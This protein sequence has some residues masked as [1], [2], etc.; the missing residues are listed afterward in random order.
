MQILERSSYLIY[1]ILIVLAILISIF[2]FYLTLDEIRKNREPEIFAYCINLEDNKKRWEHMIQE[3]K[4]VSF[5]I[6]RIDAVD[7][8]HS[9]WLNYIDMIEDESVQKLKDTIS[10]KIRKSDPD[11]TPGAVG[12]F[13]SHLKTY[14]Q[15]ASQT[16][17]PFK[18][19][20]FLILEDDNVFEPDFENR[21]KVAMKFAPKDWDI[22]LFS[23]I[24]KKKPTVL[25]NN[26]YF[27]KVHRFYLLNC[28]VINLRGINKI[29]SNFTK[30]YN[31]IDSYFSDLI[32]RDILK[33][34][35]YK[36]K[37]SHQSKNNKTDIQVFAVEK[38]K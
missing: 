34:Y 14:R 37:L 3:Q 21:F 13:L 15:I 36:D 16:Y 1:T 2:F 22:L 32:G 17:D 35:C 24:N 28:Y 19:Q 25:E 6:N 4:N 10:R 12:C 18:Q 7:T 8:R 38:K 23:Y 27:K 9:N 11:L 29:L 26:P 30:I 31:Q 33:I 20:Y 5:V